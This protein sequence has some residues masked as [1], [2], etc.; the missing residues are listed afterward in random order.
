MLD[1][2]WLERIWFLGAYLWPLLWQQHP[3]FCCYAPSPPYHDEVKTLKLSKI[4]ISSFKI[5]LG[6]YAYR[7]YETN[8]IHQFK[9]IEREQEPFTCFF[10]SL[11][12]H[13]IRLVHI[14]PTGWCLFTLVMSYL[15][16][17]MTPTSILISSQ[18]SLTNISRNSFNNSRLTP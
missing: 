2:A 3:A 14:M 15:L 1:E 16:Y 7:G 4:N 12:E 10:S 6:V 18:N 11:F 17:S 5:S 13:V 8:T 9:L